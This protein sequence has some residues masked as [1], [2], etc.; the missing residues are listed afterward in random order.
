VSMSVLLQQSRL[1]ITK[2]GR[3]LRLEEMEPSHR[4]NLL[5]YLRRRAKTLHFC[6]AGLL[7]VPMPDIDTMAYDMVSDALDREI[8]MDPAEWLE[9]QPLVIRLV[10]LAG[11][12]NS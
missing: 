8:Y 1:W 11:E 3:E 5:A 9:E 12:D 4:D 6:S 7:G 10:Q 2:D